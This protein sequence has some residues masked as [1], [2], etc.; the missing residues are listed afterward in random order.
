MSLLG[1]F[2]I[3]SVVVSYPDAIVAPDPTS[4]VTIVVCA[5][6]DGRSCS[7]HL[8]APAALLR[9]RR[10][11][12]QPG[13]LAVARCCS[14]SRRCCRCRRPTTRSGSGGCTSPASLGVVGAC[15]GLAVS[16]RMAQD[17][18]DVLGPGAPPR[19][20]GR[21]RAR[22]Q[23]GRAP[24]R[25]RRSS[26]KDPQTRDHVCARPRWRSESASDSTCPAR[27][28]RDLGLAALLHD[29]GKLETPIEILDKPSRLTAEEY[30]I[31][32]LPR[33]RRRA[34]VAGRA[35]AGERR[36]DRALAPRAASTGAA[37]P[38]V[39]SASEIPLA[40]RIIAVCDAFDA[41]THEHRVP[42]RDGD[43]RWR[44]ACCASTPA[45]SGTHR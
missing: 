41:M 5:C 9:P 19:S 39:S 15:V 23:P 18:H 33:R 11:S 45:A 40:S 6:A 10:R 27:Q 12:R 25:R 44:S 29:V 17:A 35:D 7:L 36:P 30:E 32:K 28:L 20:A 16:K 38:T 43:R 24:L 4:P 34:D 22:P 14:P 3:A 31:V 26:D 42:R 1:V 8:A 21:V 37:I 2:V 13:R